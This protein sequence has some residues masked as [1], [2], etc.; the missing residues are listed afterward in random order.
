M[1]ERGQLYGKANIGVRVGKIIN[2]YKVGKHFKLIICDNKFDYA[3][4]H[5][6]V[7]NEAKLD[8][9]YFIRTSLPQE[10]LTAAETVRSYK[11]LSNVERA[12]RSFKSVDLMVRPI[13]HRT[14]N[15]VR[16]HIFICMLAYYVQ[17]H[18]HE[19]WRPLLFTDEEQ[20]AKNTRDP[21]APAKRSDSA[22]KKTYSKCLEDGSV[23]YSFR[24]LLRHLSAI[25]RA[26]C[27][28]S[29]MKG[30]PS[31]F[32]MDTKHNNK[33]REAFNLLQKINL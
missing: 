23:V 1:T 20:E 25:V 19:A 10:R 14:E 7:Q 8:G 12:F 5:E 2:K 13:R 21:V 27:R 6:K 31:Y 11:Q 9:L 26:T 15:R 4:N 32:T 22:L 3:I 28:Y 33:Q 18:M 17:W 29:D 24:G 30:I 16:A